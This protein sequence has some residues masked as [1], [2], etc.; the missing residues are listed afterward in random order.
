MSRLTVLSYLDCCL[1]VVHSKANTERDVIA[2]LAAVSHRSCCSRTLCR[3]VAVVECLNDRVLVALGDKS[4][5]D[6]VGRMR[7][8]VETN[9]RCDAELGSLRAV[10]VR[11]ASRNIRRIIRSFLVCLCL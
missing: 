2:V 11:T 9:R 8:D 4:G 3:P 1:V 6:R 7:R 5:H 10:V